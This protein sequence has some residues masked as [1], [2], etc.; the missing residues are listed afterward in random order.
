VRQLELPRRLKPF[1]LQAGTSRYLAVQLAEAQK[2]NGISVPAETLLSYDTDA[3]TAPEK[4]VEI[5]TAPKAG[6]Y[7][8]LLGSGLIE[9][10]RDGLMFTMKRGLDT[11]V[12]Y[13][14]HGAKGWNVREILPAH[15]AWR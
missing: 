7:L 3:A 10:T 2:V 12:Q 13:A 1:G 11:S 15:L 5:G 4:R 14:S 8:P 9:G 6:E